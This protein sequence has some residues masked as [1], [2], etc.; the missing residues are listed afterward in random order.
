MSPAEGVR[1]REE[2]EKETAVN[3]SR[4]E[5]APFLLP[6]VGQ[7]LDIERRGEAFTVKACM[8]TSKLQTPTRV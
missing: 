8:V 5:S 3:G 7:K 1:R 4:E 6:T 2:G